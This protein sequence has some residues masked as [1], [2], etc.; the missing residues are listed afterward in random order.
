LQK[1][2]SAATLQLRARLRQPPFQLREGDVGHLDKKS[3][4]EIAVLLVALRQPIA[5]LRLGA[6][7]ASSP[8]QCLP[9]DGA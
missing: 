2:Q 9:A 3:A 1:R 6:S 7:I 8:P 5:A 4:N